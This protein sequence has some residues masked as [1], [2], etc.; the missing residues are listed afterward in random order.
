MKPSWMSLSFLHIG[1]LSAVVGE[2][3]TK[4]AAQNTNNGGQIL[5]G[6]PDSTLRQPWEQ[7]EHR[8]IIKMGIYD[9]EIKTKFFTRLIN[10]RS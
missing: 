8:F 2:P 4:A 3:A 6:F 5:F 9:S 7:L 1:W 10:K